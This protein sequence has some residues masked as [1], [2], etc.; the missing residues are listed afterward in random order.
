MIVKSFIFSVLFFLPCA[1]SA[2][3]S[4]RPLVEDGKHWTYDNYTP[5]QL[6]EDD[7]YYYYDLRGDTLIAGHLCLKMYS[8]NFRRSG[9]IKY[10]GALYEENKKVYYF[11][12]EEEEAE[13]LYDFDC[14]AG[15]TLH[16][17]VGNLV[18]KSIQTEENGGIA[19]KRYTLYSIDGYFNDGSIT[20]SWI[21]GVGATM[22]FFDMLPLNG[23]YNSLNACELNGETLYKAIEPDP[24]EEGYHKMGIE[25]KRWNY[26]RFHLEND[27]WHEYP[28]SYVVKGDTLIRRTRYKKLYYQDENTERFEC[29]LV[30][31][32][33]TV[34]K[35]ADLDI[36]HGSLVLTY[37][38]EFGRKD[39]G[40]V[41]TWKAENASGN[42]NWMVYG[43]DTIEVN[44]RPF[45]RYT[46]LQKY[47]EEGETLTTIEYDGEGVWH[48]IWVEGVGSATSGIEDQHPDAEPPVRKPGEYTTF[49]S[50]YEDGECIFTSEDFYI[51]TAMRS[52][53]TSTNKDTNIYDLRGHL[54]TG[55]PA[56]GVYIQNGKK[57]LVK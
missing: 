44:N 57:K 41:F 24:T 9:E 55:K 13:L 33:R 50:C 37:F 46:C 8:D 26:I 39:F 48:D 25:G 31:R 20:F 17:R 45:R 32:G 23:N 22:D 2:Q 35:N 54:L 53:R 5:A 6:A 43:V 28:Y 7:Y 10:H 49:V 4:Y 29:L 52:I 11:S 1:I 16:V 27:G 14:V 40:K 47:S 51:M 15:D 34:Y 56:K 12:P 38:F 3:D 36:S 21:D 30:E 18:V 42:T 19:I